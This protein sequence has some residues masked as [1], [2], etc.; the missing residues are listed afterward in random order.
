[1]KRHTV[2]KLLLILFLLSLRVSLILI[3]SLCCPAL[4]LLPKPLCPC[5]Q[6]WAFLNAWTHGHE[7][8]EHLVLLNGGKS[9]PYIHGNDC[10][11]Q[12]DCTAGPS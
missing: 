3:T 1:M 11:Q 6:A 4:F 5:V 8:L 7:G 2:I 9:P 12:N 10:G